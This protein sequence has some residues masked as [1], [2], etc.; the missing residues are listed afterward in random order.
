MH[1]Y[2]DSI[3]IAL[4]IIA[5]AII[6]Y[7]QERQADD[8]L[9]K[10]SELLISKNFVIRGDEKL[11]LDSRELVVGDLVNLEAGDAI[12]ADLRLISADNFSV[13]ESSLTGE[14]VSVEKN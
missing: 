11:E 1:H 4:V 7:V 3:V 14:S 2:S 6:G 13:Q 8:A 9:A 5:N 12:P 10:I